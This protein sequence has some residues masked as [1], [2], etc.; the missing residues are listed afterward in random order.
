M[1][2]DMQ[3]VVEIAAAGMLLLFA[4]LGA[5]VSLMYL[6]TNPTIFGGPGREARRARRKAR[7]LKKRGQPVP[8]VPDEPKVDVRQERL[9]EH[10]RRRRAAALAAAIACAG[11][12]SA[13]VFNHDGPAEWR[14]LHRS[15]RLHQRVAP[16]PVVA[17]AP[18]FGRTSPKPGR[19]TA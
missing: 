19:G 17:P 9:D 12:D 13:M 10:D 7:R 2:P 5:L 4:A 3:V 16:R 15:L 6:L 18:R 11:Q 14:L 1:S 8:V